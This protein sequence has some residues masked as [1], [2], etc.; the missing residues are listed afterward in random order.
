MSAIG[1]A[2]GKNNKINLC[3]FDG[4][5]KKELERR[6]KLRLEQVCLLSFYILYTKQFQCLFVWPFFY[7]NSP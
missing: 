6:K 1:A 3:D 4:V 7:C 5:K 2:N